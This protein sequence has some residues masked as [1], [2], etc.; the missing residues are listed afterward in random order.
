MLLAL[1][2]LG[3]SAAAL[4]A[5]L[6]LMIDL[7]GWQ[8]EKADGADMSAATGAKAVAVFRTYQ[9][10]DRKFEVSVLVGMQASASW[11][12]DYKE[13][14]KTESAGAVIEVRRIG[15]FLVYDSFETESKSGGIIVLLQAAQDGD[16]IL[17]VSYEGLSREE[18]M[19]LA[20]KFNWPKMKAEAA[21]LK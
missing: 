12:P 14:Y 21:K 13:G 3:A 17:G 9:D 8:A 10:G 16:A 4:D 7:P 20:Q 19:A 2:A 1:P 15:G 5:L 11:L 18:G 6:P